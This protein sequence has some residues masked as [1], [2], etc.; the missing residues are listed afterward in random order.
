MAQAAFEVT[1]GQVFH[2]DEILPLVDA[3]VEDLDDMG[4]GQPGDHAP[5]VQE[6]LGEFDVET[7]ARVHDLEG[8]LAL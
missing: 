1:T 5:F 4:M 3:G 8:H 6:A 7:K 2:G